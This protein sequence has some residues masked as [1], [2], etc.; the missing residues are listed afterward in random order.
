VFSWQ[1]IGSQTGNVKDQQCGENLGR[2]SGSKVLPV[3][4]AGG[5]AKGIFPK[6]PEEPGL[7][8]VM[9]RRGKQK[10]KKGLGH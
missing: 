2:G 3:K 5:K 8:G 9:E 6:K 4:E 1:A 7:T 10:E